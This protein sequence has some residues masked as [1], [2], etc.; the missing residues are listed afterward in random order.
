MPALT[1]EQKAVAF[2]EKVAKCRGILPPHATNWGLRESIRL[3]DPD[4]EG[5]RRHGDI[6]ILDEVL[7]KYGPLPAGDRIL[8]VACFRWMNDSLWHKCHIQQGRRVCDWCDLSEHK[9]CVPVS[10]DFSSFSK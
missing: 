5:T 7:N 6:R 9:R 4:P 3:P 1:E 10:R 8:C 2:A